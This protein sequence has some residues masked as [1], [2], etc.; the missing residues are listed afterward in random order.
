MLVV[1]RGGPEDQLEPCLLLGRDR[2]LLAHDVLVRHRGVAQHARIARRRGDEEQ[3]GRVIHR[4][5]L[6][7]QVFPGRVDIRAEQVA[8][9]RPGEQGIA[10]DGGRRG[11][12]IGRI[13]HQRDGAVHLSLQ[14]LEPRRE[15]GAL[16]FLRGAVLVPRLDDEGRRE[17]LVVRDL[18]QVVVGVRDVERTGA[19]VRHIGLIH[20]RDDDVERGLRGRNYGLVVPVDAVNEGVGVGEVCRGS[21]HARDKGLE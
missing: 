8:R 13:G 19:D 12:E 17:V 9:G 3:V 1:L 6:V 11:A 21:A 14:G 10:R 7:D 18:D 15:V 4:H 2:C 16:E 5:A 20:G